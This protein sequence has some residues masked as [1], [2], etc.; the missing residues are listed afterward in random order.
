MIKKKVCLLG[1]FGVGKT[2]LVRRFVQ[3]IFDERYLATLGVKIDRKDVLTADG[4]TVRLM[5]WDLAGED[6]G[7]PLRLSYIHGASAC[8]YVADLTRPETI[9]TAWG[10]AARVREQLGDMPSILLMLNKKDL[11]QE[12][13]TAADILKPF[14]ENGC[15]IRQTSAKTGEGVEEAFSSLASR[16]LSKDK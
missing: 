15:P 7:A 2:S 4:E 14:T 16:L 5:L 10:I 12:Q 1:A 8:L 6:V 9:V 11:Y 13:D 3:G